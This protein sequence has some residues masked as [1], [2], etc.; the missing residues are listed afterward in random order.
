MIEEVNAPSHPTEITE[1]EY[2]EHADRYLD[3]LNEQA[4][5]LQESRQDVEV[6]FS[7]SV[8]RPTEREHR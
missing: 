2:H 4:E 6:D 8:Q 7:V 5:A 1:E 3:T